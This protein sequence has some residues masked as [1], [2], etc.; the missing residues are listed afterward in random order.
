LAALEPVEGEGGVGFFG[1]VEDI[2]DFHLHAEGCFEG[3]EAGFEDGVAGV[4][5]E[6]GAVEG[7]EGGEFALLLRDGDARGDVGDGFRAG[8]DEGPS[9]L[10]RTRHSRARGNPC[11]HGSPIRSGLTVACHSRPRPMGWTPPPRRHRNVPKWR[12]L[13]TH[14]N[15]QERPT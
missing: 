7:G 8:D 13:P 1:E 14:L 6:V 10:P 9:F 11:S 4:L 15:R 5:G 2:G 3:A 12:C